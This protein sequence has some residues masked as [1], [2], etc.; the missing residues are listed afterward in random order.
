MKSIIK[1][2]LE[3]DSVQ[4]MR[5]GVN[6]GHSTLLIGYKVKPGVYSHHKKL[7]CVLF[8]DKEHLHIVTD[9]EFMEIPLEDIIDVM[10]NIE[11]FNFVCKEI[12]HD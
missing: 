9:N 7:R 12:L 4:D 5:P 11:K 10:K 8:I 1:S 3:L 2:P 6:G